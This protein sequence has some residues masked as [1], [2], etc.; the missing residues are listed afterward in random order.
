MQDKPTPSTAIVMLQ[1]LG[2]VLAFAVPTAVAALLVPAYAGQIVIGAI[3]LLFGVSGFLVGREW[4]DPRWT[5]ETRWHARNL[6]FVIVSIPVFDL[7]YDVIAGRSVLVPNLA[8]AAG[9]I[10]VILT[11]ILAPFYLGIV[12]HRR[13]PARG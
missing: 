7:I 11:A 4:D 10:A 6:L 2:Y 8:F 9:Y 5:R 3:L 12:M 1:M 13:R